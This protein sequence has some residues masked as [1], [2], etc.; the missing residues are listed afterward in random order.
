MLQLI[1]KGFPLGTYVIINCQLY[2]LSIL[3][4][5]ID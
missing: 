1:P 4:K 5:H 3:I 2:G